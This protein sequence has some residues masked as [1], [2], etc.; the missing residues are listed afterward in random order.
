MSVIAH[1]I[2]IIKLLIIS[3]CFCGG[4]LTIAEAKAS[5]SVR[6]SKQEW[7]FTNKDNKNNQE[8]SESLREAITDWQKA[9]TQ[10]D[11]K[12]C[13]RML[14]EH[15]LMVSQNQAQIL[16]GREA[17]M[18]ALPKEWEYYETDDNGASAL[19]STLRRVDA[20]MRGNAALVHYYMDVTGGNRWSFEDT[21]AFTQI[22]VRDEVENKWQL[23]FSAD[24]WNLDYDTDS[25]KAGKPVFA[26]DYA[27]PVQDLA[28][29]VKFY[30]PLLGEPEAL[31]KNLAVFEVRE[32]RLYL[33]T[34]ETVDT[35][36]RSRAGLPNGWAI[37]TP[38]NFEQA[39]ENSE[40]HGVKF[41]ETEQNFGG[42]KVLY[43]YE[44]SGNLIALARSS[45]SEAVVK[46]PVLRIAETLAGDKL[47]SAIATAD[48]HLWTAWLKG[49][50]SEFIAQCTTDIVLLDATR[51]RTQGWAN[52]QKN[53][54]KRLSNTF[55]NNEAEDSKTAWQTRHPFAKL[56]LTE[57]HTRRVGAWTVIARRSTGVGVEPWQRRLEALD[58]RIFETE[59]AQLAVSLTVSAA[60]A[61]GIALE[62]DYAGIPVTK[63]GW[64][65][66]DKALQALT[67][68]AAN[69]HDEQ[70]KGF[71]G[72]RAVLGMFE[73]ELQTDKM[74]RNQ[75][76][77]T[78]LSLLVS[79][80][81]T[82]MT[83]LKATG[84]KFPIIPAINDK[85]GISK[86]AG[87]NQ[88]LFTDSE[89]NGVVLTEYTGRSKRTAK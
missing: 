76:A 59:S 79:K 45:A 22:F 4:I 63:A 31:T 33:V 62:F 21:A 11:V 27:M 6:L 78:Y 46:H 58:T 81:E 43:G 40:K 47:P 60:P 5:E 67:G 70:W 37:L 88:V 82:A 65:A 73:T 13:R 61:R 19:Q 34:A 30:Q 1:N 77:S 7:H 75:E 17:V 32:S 55:G 39:K 18:K 41:S 66:T 38:P 71:W 48:N 35:F 72:E 25:G 69:Y 15:V 87:Y 85:A 8:E 83:H 49:E 89:G 52:G 56:N 2:K 9:W 42:L 26:Y 36:T 10:R 80:L 16:S 3:I 28:R 64:K 53:V 14:S 68:D 84:A 20:E 86:Y 51:T 57:G 44:P 50:T 24:V 12:A 54:R 23:A 74:P 29:A